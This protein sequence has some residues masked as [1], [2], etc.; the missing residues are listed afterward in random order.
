MKLQIDTEA[1]AIRLEENVNIAE[2]VE[3]LKDLF[4][5]DEWKSY[6]IETIF[7][8]IRI[9]EKEYNP[10]YPYPWL[11]PTYPSPSIPVMPNWPN[12]PIIYGTTTAGVYNI[13]V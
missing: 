5:N 4:P 7:T 11:T 1:L 2:L 9:V 12:N 8:E 6:T 3:V 10:V 13:S